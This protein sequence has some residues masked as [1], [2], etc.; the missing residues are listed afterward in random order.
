MAHKRK[1]DFQLDRDNYGQAVKSSL[2]A[3][4]ELASENDRI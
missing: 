1:A 3:G 4:T 2:P